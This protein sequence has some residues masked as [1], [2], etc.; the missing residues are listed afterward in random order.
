MSRVAPGASDD[1]VDQR[2]GHPVRVLLVD[3]QTLVRAGFR[4]VLDRDPDLEV[5][6][7]A[8]DGDQAVDLARLHRPDVV[9]M[10][11]RM[12]HVDGIEATR[13]ICGDPRLAETRVVVLT[14]YELD[15]YV[16]TALQ[17]GASGFL[18]K[19]VE[20]DDLRRAVHLVAA[21]EGLLSPSVTTRVISALRDQADRQPRHPERLD[22][23]TDREREVVALV[24]Q[25]LNNQE[26][27]RELY[28]AAATAKTH[29]SR[30]MTKLHARDR[31]QLVVIAHET[32][33]V[34][35]G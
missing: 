34:R 8:G 21:G 32:G 9:L 25:G 24:G 19:D 16:V 4:L 33:L 27:G 31:V 10:D 6:G 23:L 29:V 28:M 15:E 18:L 2:A 11:I 5:V 26:I 13:R 20:P 3:D 35:H 1:P 7:E 22:L 12:P 14:T 30:A 17:V